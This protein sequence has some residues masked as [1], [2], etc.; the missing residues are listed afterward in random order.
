MLHSR[1]LRKERLRNTAVFV[2]VLVAAFVVVFVVIT[3]IYVAIVVV[4]FNCVHA[5]L[6]PA[7]SV[8]LSV[9]HAFTFFIFRSHFKTFK[10]ILRHSKLLCKSRTRLIGVGL[11]P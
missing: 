10:S 1:G 9:C 7:L 4:V 3:I 6:Q 2:A 8:G 5:T 11:V